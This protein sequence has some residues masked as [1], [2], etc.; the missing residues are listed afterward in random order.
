MSTM[1]QLRHHFNGRVVWTLL[2]FF[3]LLLNLQEVLGDV[4][5]QESE[6]LLK[7][8]D[9]LEPICSGL[10]CDRAKRLLLVHA[11]RRPRCFKNLFLRLLGLESNSEKW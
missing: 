11:G 8:F 6:K 7:K 10:Y 9:P 2:P 3:F 4:M 5:K 1:L